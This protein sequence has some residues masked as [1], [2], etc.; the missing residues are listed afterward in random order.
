VIVDGK[1]KRRDFIKKSVGTGAAALIGGGLGWPRSGSGLSRSAISEFPDVAVVQGEDYLASTRKAVDLIGGIERFVPKNARVAILPNTQSAHPGT[2]TKPDIVRAVVRM[3]KTA[4]ASE[5]NCLSWLPEKFWMAT[6]LAGVLKEE[7]AELKLVDLKAEALFKP[8]ALPKGKILREAMIMAEFFNND[9]LINLPITKDHAG[10]KFTGAMKNLMALNFAQLNRTFHSGDF[11]TNPDDIDRLD[12]C[13]A[14][15]N[16]AVKPT[17]CIVD[18]TE[19]ITTNG[20]FGP[21]ELA[22]PR[23]IVAGVDRIAVDS[24]CASL[25]GLKGEDILMIK[26]GHEHGLGEINLKKVRI[27]EFAA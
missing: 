27:Q 3:C 23:K 1:L 4:G 19:F 7:G 17:L 11:K 6:G 21:G 10:N 22:T 24:Y 2:F 12:Q 9:C 25:R 26:K 15:L 20:P 14:D 16:L 13:I 18:A 8:V 5:V